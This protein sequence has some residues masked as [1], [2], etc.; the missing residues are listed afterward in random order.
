MCDQ[1]SREILK[2]GDT[3]DIYTGIYNDRTVQANQKSVVVKHVMPNYANHKSKFI[4]WLGAC[5]QNRTRFIHP[6]ICPLLGVMYTGKL[7]PLLVYDHH[8]GGNLLEY[9]RVKG[10]SLLFQDKLRVMSGIL[11]ALVRLHHEQDIAWGDL[12]PGNIMLDESGNPKLCGLGP[13]PSLQHE[14]ASKSDLSAIRYFGPERYRAEDTLLEKAGDVWAFGCLIVKVGSKDPHENDDT[15]FE[16][17]QILNGRDPYQ[18]ARTAYGVI[19]AVTSGRW[20]YEKSDCDNLPLWNM[21]SACWIESV[22]QR[23]MTTSLVRRIETLQ[24]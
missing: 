10:Q 6:N 16:D 14:A 9:L 4:L 22:L 19:Q 12:H 8:S 13:R 5:A 20:P 2:E 1:L 21:A 17:S 18:E 23:P 11:D 7:E 24:T 3:A 15:F